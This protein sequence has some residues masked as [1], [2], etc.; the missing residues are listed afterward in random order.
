[1]V[2]R[3]QILF[4]RTYKLTFNVPTL[5]PC[6]NRKVFPPAFLWQVSYRSIPLYPLW[7]RSDS[8]SASSPPACCGWT[9]VHPLSCCC[10]TQTVAP[11][12]CQS[13]FKPQAQRSTREQL[14]RT[15]PLTEY[16][17]SYSAQVQMEAED[18]L[19]MS[20]SHSHLL[21][22]VFMFL[23]TQWLQPENRQT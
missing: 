4:A 10:G 17:A 11:H 9:S 15:L 21:I 6:R 12:M 1:M 14:S 18:A 5:I 3:L 23:S 19:L 8:I 16:Q 7:L 22:L 2:Q 13:E 20:P